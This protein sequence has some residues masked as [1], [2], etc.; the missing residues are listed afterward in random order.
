MAILA[1]K[2]ASSTLRLVIPS[3]SIFTIILPS[4]LCNIQLHY[5]TTQDAR[6]LPD[7]KSMC[8]T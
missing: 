3:N 4:L 1:L 5:S 7:A 2:M 8:D 6:E